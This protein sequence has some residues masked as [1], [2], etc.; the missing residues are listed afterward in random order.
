MRS[1]SNSRST[2][3]TSYPP[4]TVLVYDLKPV[5][6]VDSDRLVQL[7][8]FLVRLREDVWY[9][10]GS[11]KTSLAIS[12]PVISGFTPLASVNSLSF[13]KM[14]SFRMLSS[15]VEYRAIREIGGVFGTDGLVVW[16]FEIPEQLDVQR[17]P[18]QLAQRAAGLVGS[19]RLL[20][21]VIDEEGELGWALTACGLRGLVLW[22]GIEHVALRQIYD[23]VVHKGHVV[24]AVEVAD[25]DVTR[26]NVGLVLQN[27]DFDLALRRRDELVLD[28][29]GPFWLR[30][31]VLFLFGQGI[32]LGSL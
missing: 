11:S 3:V 12:A 9:C 20:G 10:V 7:D 1:F 27:L 21:A 31:A 28:S 18:E 14:V 17:V 25:E 32:C 16:G 29:C 6:I 26:R 30:A 24:F 5:T 13:T 19:E 22:D 4:V 2:R 8:F 15:C 23:L